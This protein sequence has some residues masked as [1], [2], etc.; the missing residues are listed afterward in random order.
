MMSIFRS[1]TK[2][3]GDVPDAF[4]E[5]F[6]RSP[7]PMIFSGN[8]FNASPLPR[9][10]PL[11]SLPGQKTHIFNQ[12]KEQS[13]F[14]AKGSPLRLNTSRSHQSI[15]SLKQLSNPEEFKR[16][17]GIRGGS[18]SETI[19]ISS[20]TPYTT[21]YYDDEIVRR[22]SSWQNGTFSDDMNETSRLNRQNEVDGLPR[23]SARLFG[24]KNKRVISNGNHTSENIFEDGAVSPTSLE[25][26][27]STLPEKSQSQVLTQKSKSNYVPALQSPASIFKRMKMLSPSKNYKKDQENQ[28]PGMRN[29]VEETLQSDQEQRKYPLDVEISIHTEKDQIVSSNLPNRQEDDIDVQQISDTMHTYRKQG[30]DDDD[31]IILYDKEKE[32]VRPTQPNNY[33]LHSWIIKPVPGVCGICVDGKLNESD[34]QFFQSSIVTSRI[35]KKKITTTNGSV[36]TLVGNMEKTEALNAGITQDIV[37]SFAAGFPVKWKDIIDDYFKKVKFI[38]EPV[39]VS[40]EEDN[41][42]K[43]FPQE[44]SNDSELEEPLQNDIDESSSKTKGKE[45]KEYSLI[46]W[47]IKPIINTETICV[48]GMKSDT[49]EYWHSTAID[50]VKDKRTLVTTSGSIYKLHGKICKLETLEEGFSQRIVKAFHDGFPRSWKS[51]IK[52]HFSGI[53]YQRRNEDIYLT[54]KAGNNSRSSTACTANGVVFELDSL[55]KSSTGRVI[56]PVLAWWTGQRFK[57][58]H[59]NTFELTYNSSKTPEMLKAMSESSKVLGHLTTSFGG[60][61]KNKTESEQLKVKTNEK[62]NKRNS[63]ENENTKN[64]N[65]KRNSSEKRKTDSFHEKTLKKDKGHGKTKYSSSLKR[66]SRLSDNNDLDSLIDDLHN[67]VKKAKSGTKSKKVNQDTCYNKLPKSFTKKSSAEEAYSVDMDSDFEEDEFKGHK[68]NKA[69]N[70]NN[71]RRMKSSSKSQRENGTKSSSVISRPQNI[72]RQK[73]NKNSENTVISNSGRLMRLRTHSYNTKMKYYIEKLNAEDESSDKDESESSDE[74]DFSKKK[75]TVKAK[76]TQSRINKPSDSEDLEWTK[77]EINRLNR[78]VK[79]IPID[80]PN[81]WEIVTEKVKTRSHEE[82]AAYYYKVIH[83]SVNTKKTVTTTEK[84]TDFKGITAKKGTLKRKQQLREFVEH[85]NNGYDDD[86]YDSTPY[87]KHGAVK[88]PKIMDVSDGCISKEMS[89]RYTHLNS[90]YTPMARFHFDPVS[91]KK[92]P[93]TSSESASTHID[94]NEVVKRIY[95]VQKKRHMKGRKILSDKTAVNKKHHNHKTV[96]SPTKDLFGTQNLFVDEGSSSDNYKD[97]DNESDYYFSDDSN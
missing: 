81:F 15:Q 53:K 75:G 30:S 31:D 51:L 78:A 63:L 88:I 83:K 97:S 57:L 77:P 47:F 48:E 13:Q 32:T 40:S 72:N 45:V 86:L 69:K 68:K 29:K 79:E 38:D 36:Y 42:G 33:K 67:T 8:N 73:G 55:K 17:E 25:I 7:V 39:A 62:V 1:L 35:N 54:P 46:D 4:E 96:K 58:N 84:T 82:C 3:Q 19:G 64:P 94:R 87:R 59:D 2:T 66:G 26:N 93:A 76:R 50:H 20:Q 44:N 16:P 10:V 43:D 11:T 24:S 12:L 56:K 5:L 74:D 49:D 52:A 61:H 89:K 60:K 18:K 21:H 6:Q 90:T 65:S 92:T 23:N 71:N 22:N 28:D 91:E 14:N 95:Q 85:H 9:I 41:I 37:K 27:D 34:E 80:D 70:Q